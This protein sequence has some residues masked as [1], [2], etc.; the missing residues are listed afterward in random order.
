MPLG[1]GQTDN[2]RLET[3]YLCRFKYKI[4]TMPNLICRYC[5]T[6][7]Y[8]AG[9]GEAYLHKDGSTKCV[10]PQV[11][12]LKNL[13]TPIDENVTYPAYRADLISEMTNHTQGYP[14]KSD[15][16][17]EMILADSRHFADANDLNFDEH[18]RRSYE[19]YLEDQKDTD[20][21]AANKKIDF[22]SPAF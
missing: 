16:V 7:S 8:V 3:I 4:A 11:E 2:P 21:A 19:L 6:P 14:D 13:A 22:S 18:E 1:A 12:G 20:D 9:D 15:K 17:L 5:K 10:K